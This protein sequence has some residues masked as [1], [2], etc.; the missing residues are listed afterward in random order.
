MRFR[1]TVS[2]RRA[3]HLPFQQRHALLATRFA[4][5]RFSLP[6]YENGA[7]SV[8][9]PADD[10]A[11]A[12]ADSVELESE[13]ANVSPEQQI[14]TLALPRQPKYHLDLPRAIVGLV[15]GGTTA[16]Y[17]ARNTRGNSADDDET[18]Q[19][20]GGQNPTDQPDKK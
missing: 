4:P 8:S 14:E 2:C 19:S 6:G 5:C 15:L 11:I 10:T 18:E 17:V 12:A 13:Q 16:W 1:K 20:D 9:L 7:Q 3:T